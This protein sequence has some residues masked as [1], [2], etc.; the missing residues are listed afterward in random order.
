M[1]DPTAAM[2]PDADFRE[3]EIPTDHDVWEVY[4]RLIGHA[5]SRRPGDD[6]WTEIMIYRMP[7][8]DEHPEPRYIIQRVGRS[9]RY[10]SSKARCRSGGK[11]VSNIDV[12]AWRMP[13]PDCRPPSIDELEEIQDSDTSLYK[14]E[15]DR[16]QAIVVTHPERVKS[17]L[18]HDKGL[19]TVSNDALEMARE[20]DPAL[21]EVI[22]VRKR[23][24]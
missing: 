6:R 18:T 8:T 2:V 15:S 4:C 1:T 23:I 9:V 11:F 20:V 19:S 21:R 7:A 14:V 5:S 12:E 3:H 17:S 10:H 16:S 24:A 13:C 22:G